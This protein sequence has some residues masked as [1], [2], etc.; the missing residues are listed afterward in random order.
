MQSAK[1]KYGYDET[2]HEIAWQ[3]KCGYDDH[4]KPNPMTTM[5]GVYRHGAKYGYRCD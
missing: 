4:C 1:A 2:E 5:I 3:A